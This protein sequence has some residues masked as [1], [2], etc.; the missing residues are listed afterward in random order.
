MD[1]FQTCQHVWRGLQS[2]LSSRFLNLA[3]FKFPLPQRDLQTTPKFTMHVVRMPAETCAPIVACLC[4]NRWRSN[5]QWC[6][7]WS[8]KEICCEYSLKGRSG[9][10]P[11]AA[12]PLWNLMPIFRRCVS[13]DDKAHTRWEREEWPCSCLPY[14]HLDRF[15]LRRKWLSQGVRGE[16]W[17]LE[18]IVGLHHDLISVLTFQEAAG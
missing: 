5:F 16:R 6:H 14:E 4:S 1:L 8:P 15:A 18:V 17:N 7:N 3:D 13:V 11:L 12:P 2:A 10:D 9:A